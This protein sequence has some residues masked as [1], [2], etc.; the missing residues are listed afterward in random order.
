MK[1]VK[2]IIGGLALVAFSC[3]KPEVV[4]SP[5][6]DPIATK[7]FFDE[8]VGEATQTFTVDSESSI[9]ITGE[10]GTQLSIPG[11]SF[12]NGSGDPVTGNIEIELIEINCKAEMVT[13]NKATNGLKSGGL[14]APLVSAGELFVRATQYGV[15]ISATND[16]AVAMPSAEYDPSMRKFLDVSVDEDLLW[17]MAED[18]LLEFVGDSIE[19]SYM[20]FD[21]LPDDWGWVNCDKF[22]NNSDPKTTMT[23]SLPEGFTP[24][25]ATIFISLDG[26][27]SILNYYSTV[28]LPIGLDVHFIGVGVV[29]DELHYDIEP[30]TIVNGHVQDLDGFSAIS[31]DALVSLIDALP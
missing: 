25:N 29:G 4:P 5:S 23:L 2:Y 31:E 10:K 20:L 28:E 1:N 8:N 21:V 17:E 6:P 15:E 22:Y 9:N 30:A 26:E 19:G 11:N 14:K 13:M 24:E 7:I 18:S 27:M 16:M 3:N 12:V